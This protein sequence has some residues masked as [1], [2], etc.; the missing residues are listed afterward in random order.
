MWPSSR[1]IAKK[2]IEERP[3]TSGFQEMMASDT[4][5]VLLIEDN[6]GD[7]GLIRRMLRTA[8]NPPIEMQH[9]STFAS[10]LGPLQSG[11]VDLLLL[12]LALPGST[13]FDTIASAIAA[14]PDVPIIVMTGTD[15]TQTILECIKAGAKDYFVKSRTDPE[16]LIEVIGRC[17][18]RSRADES[19]K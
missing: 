16:R 12:D 6:P 5:R 10:G 3:R 4:I 2:N 1:V 13:G 15:A 18:R 19:P 7:A 11:I 14:A 8:E 17:A 9:A